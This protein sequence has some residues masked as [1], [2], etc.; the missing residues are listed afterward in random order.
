MKL[1]Q[2]YKNKLCPSKSGY[3][4]DVTHCA[5]FISCMMD[6]IDALHT[7]GGRG[8]NNVESDELDRELIKLVKKDNDGT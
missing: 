3:I 6:E 4:C 8:T 5:K 7:I 1:E 2:I